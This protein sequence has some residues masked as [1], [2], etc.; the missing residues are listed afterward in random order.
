MSESQRETDQINQVLPVPVRWMDNYPA[1][2]GSGDGYENYVD[3][4]Q[5]VEGHISE[6]LCVHVEGWLKFTK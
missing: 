5:V 6:Y 4:L 3:F 2:M 1:R